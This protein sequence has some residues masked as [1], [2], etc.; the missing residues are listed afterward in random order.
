MVDGFQSGSVG[1]IEEA[2]VF[3]LVPAATVSF[4]DVRF[5][6]FHASADL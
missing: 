6:G 4:D 5:H 1:E 2:D 3:R